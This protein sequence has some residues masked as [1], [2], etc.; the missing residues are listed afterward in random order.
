[1]K[2][3]AGIID[4]KEVAIFKDPK[5]DNGLKKSAKGF[6]AVREGPNGYELHDELT[7]NEIR[8]SALDIVFQ[9]GMAF[10]VES[11]A[12]IRERLSS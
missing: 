2:A 6:L 7:F 9:N 12:E 11:L 1:M 4:G 3:T 8:Q 10:N 5:T